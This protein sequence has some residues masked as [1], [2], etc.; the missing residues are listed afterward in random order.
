MVGG[1]N[2]WG[3]WW[4]DKSFIRDERKSIDSITMKDVYMY[5]SLSRCKWI[6]NQ[7]R[8]NNW[9]EGRVM[10]YCMCIGNV[11]KLLAVFRNFKQYLGIISSIHKLWTVARNYRQYLGIVS[12]KWE[13]WADTA[14]NNWELWA[15][16]GIVSSMSSGL[17]YAKFPHYTE[18]LKNLEFC[19]LPFQVWERN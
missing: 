7:H 11:G 19:I 12:C 4:L 8:K 9:C 5:V 18:H 17:C 14:G 3:W 2:E 1:R 15:M 6:I 16:L 13:L 10:V